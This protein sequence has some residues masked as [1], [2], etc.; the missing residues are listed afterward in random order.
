MSGKE[1]Q[2]H[3]IVQKTNYVEC[4]HAR[5]LANMSIAMRSNIP[6]PPMYP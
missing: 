1:K 5:T 6:P 3:Y 4:L 2:Q